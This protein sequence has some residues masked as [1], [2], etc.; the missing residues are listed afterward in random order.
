MEEEYFNCDTFIAIHDVFL[1]EN[2][3]HEILFTMLSK[4][5]IILYD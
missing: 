5:E 4:N 3:V 2:S 1:E